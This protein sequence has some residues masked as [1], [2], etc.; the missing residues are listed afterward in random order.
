M[1]INAFPDWIITTSYSVLFDQNGLKQFTIYGA[2]QPTTGHHI[3]VTAD[4]ELIGAQELI[5]QIFNLSLTQP[6]EE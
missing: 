4:N 5:Q 2:S 6:F 1:S 3:V